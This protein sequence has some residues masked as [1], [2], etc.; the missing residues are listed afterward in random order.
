[1]KQFSLIFTM[2]L[3][4]VLTSCASKKELSTSP[5][6]QIEGATVQKWLAGMQKGASGYMLSIPVYGMDNDIVLDQ[7]FYKG[8]VSS[9]TIETAADHVTATAKFYDAIH[10]T[11]DINMS[12]DS[13]DEFGNKPP[14]S[15][16]SNKDFP[17]ELQE[18]EAVLSYIEE[19]QL[20][21]VKVTN[22]KEKS[23]KTMPTAKG[24]N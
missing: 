4:L 5:S 21:Y 1:M 14:S 23:P 12:E 8:Q 20:K 18:N 7:V 15:I 2:C 19:N 22:I 13:K 9:L 11:K 6:F 3:F 17:F 16:K 10:L 24:T